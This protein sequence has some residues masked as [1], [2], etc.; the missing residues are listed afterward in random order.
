VAATTTTGVAAPAEAEPLTPAPLHPPR[1]VRAHCYGYHRD[2]AL[3]LRR[4][5]LDLRAN[6][7]GE[8]QEG[9][10]TI[11]FKVTGM[12]W[13]GH[14]VVSGCGSTTHFLKLEA[15]ADDKVKLRTSFEEIRKDYAKK[16]RRRVAIPF[17]HKRRNESFPLPAMNRMLVQQ[18]SSQ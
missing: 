14:R 17:N 15:L 7:L 18:S 13:R 3:K 6:I 8:D 2:L 11:G 10:M 5:Y 12:R 9:P 4:G 1:S 16:G